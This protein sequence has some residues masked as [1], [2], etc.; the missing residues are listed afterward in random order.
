M[1]MV[2]VI[3]LFLVVLGGLHFALT[4]LGINLLT[5]L[6][7]GANLPILYLAMGVSTLW[8]AMPVLKTKLGAL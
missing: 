8:L 6:F 5:I 3:A 1:K 7:G 2:H 4:G